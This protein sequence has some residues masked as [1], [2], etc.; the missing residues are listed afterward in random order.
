MSREEAKSS[1]A[2]LKRLAQVLGIKKHEL[3]CAIGEGAVKLPAKND[4]DGRA[5]T[6]EE[7]ILIAIAAIMHKHGFR[8]PAVRE[9]V[10]R[11]T[12]QL[13]ERKNVVVVDFRDGFPMQVRIPM[14]TLL[15][16]VQ[17]L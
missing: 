7:V 5:F 17:N 6:E 11:A 2:Q 3:R 14:S 13:Q 15:Q 8:G 10:R 9:I 16:R 4:E 12:S 1:G